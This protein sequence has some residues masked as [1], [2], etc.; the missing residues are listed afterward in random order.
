MLEIGN[1]G[2]GILSPLQVRISLEHIMLGIGNI[3]SGILIP[4]QVRISLEFIM[5]GIGNIGSGI[6][7]PLQVRI[8]LEYIMLRIGNIGSGILIP[9]QVK[10]SLEF[11]T[12]LSIVS[13]SGNTRCNEFFLVKLLT[14]EFG[15]IPLLF[16][17]VSLRHISDKIPY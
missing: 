2:S 10:I 9:L 1:I 7:I 16:K 6:L 8:S 14:Q 3:G 5:L 15:R 11:I 4:L 13:H 17:H 12:K